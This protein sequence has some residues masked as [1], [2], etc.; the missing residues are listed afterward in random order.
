MSA[1]H[2]GRAT[3]GLLLACGAAAVLCAC[4]QTAMVQTTARMRDA[5]V[6]KNY[7]AALAILRKS[8]KESF[9]EQDRVVY[10]MNEGM[11]LHL[12]GRYTESTKVLQ[13]AEARTEELYTKSIS[14]GIKSA[15]TSNAATDYKGED[16]ENVLV[17]VVKA[18]NFL[19]RSNTEGALVEARKINGK[20]HLYNQRLE[21]KNVYNQDA[22]AHWLTGILYEIEGSFDDARISYKKALHT[23]KTDFAGHY[24]LKPPPYLRED[25]A[26]AYFRTADWSNLQKM[27]SQFGPQMGSTA[28]KL[29]AHGE[30]ILFHLNGEGPT[31]SDYFVTCFFHNPADWHCDGEP[32]EEFVK[33]TTI[34]IPEGATVVKV[35]FPQIHTHRPGNPYMEMTVAGKTTRSFVALPISAI[36]VKAMR[37]KLPRIWKDAIIRAVTKAATTKG[38][39]AAGHA[40]GGGLLGGLVEKVT[41]AAMQATEEADKRAWTTLPSRIEVARLFVPAGVHN[42]QV[43]LPR[44]GRANITGVKVKAGKRVLITYRTLP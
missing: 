34:H 31:K 21:K 40:A 37:D 25:L 3:R 39:G 6:A 24:G 5:V 17:N 43:H 42:V 7:D 1:S 2:F 33:K 20:L 26:R 10:W 38:A 23:Y 44:G 15:F 27:K 18:L 41:S 16:Y 22:F 29:K 12:M 32:G 19:G 14:K 9:K 13:K 36:A 30:I 35:A 28:K 11:L 4:G 8:K